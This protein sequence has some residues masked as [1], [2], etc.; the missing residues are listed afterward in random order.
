MCYT[1]SGSRPAVGSDRTLPLMGSMGMKRPDKVARAAIDWLSGKS[2]DGREMRRVIEEVYPGA[3]A[4][5]R[6]AQVK[7]EHDARFTGPVPLWAKR[8]VEKHA[9]DH[10]TLQVRQS[11]SKVTTSGRCY[12]GSRLVVTFGRAHRL[13]GNETPEAEASIREQQERVESDHRI[14]VLHEIAHTRAPWDDHGP[15]FYAAFRKLLVA[16]GLLR[17]AEKRY[18]KIRAGKLRQAASRG[19]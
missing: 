6:A 3:I 1:V 4:R 19:R 8:Y 10:V 14:V 2:P 7:A 13:Y 9:S 16:E 11:R 18:G 12:G 17:A 15:K 5:A